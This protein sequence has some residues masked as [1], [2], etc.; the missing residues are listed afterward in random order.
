MKGLDLTA[1]S[2]DDVFR[3]RNLRNN[4]CPTAAIRLDRAAAGQEVDPINPLESLPLLS[5]RGIMGHVDGN[6]PMVLPGSPSDLHEGL[7]A[8]LQ[9]P[10]ARAIVVIEQANRKPGHVFNAEN[11]N[12]KVWLF[13][14]YDGVAV[15]LDGQPTGVVSVEGF[16]PLAPIKPA[17]GYSA[18]VTKE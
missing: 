14:A 13:E 9:R 11:I 1:A 5:P 3:L 17:G 2:D 12:G 18:I 6:A 7:R 16:Y 15:P 10:G 4:S 8:L